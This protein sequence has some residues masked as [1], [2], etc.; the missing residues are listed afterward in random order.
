MGF[1]KFCNFILK[2]ENFSKNT[3]QNSLETL[4]EQKDFDRATVNMSFEETSMCLVPVMVR[5]KLSNRIVKTYAVR[6]CC[7]LLQATFPKENLLSDLGVQGRKTSITVNT[8]NGEVI[9]SSE[10]SN[11]KSERI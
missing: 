7:A 8:M 2:C 4:P 1:W 3:N 10:A 5:H 11:G 9:K 6:L